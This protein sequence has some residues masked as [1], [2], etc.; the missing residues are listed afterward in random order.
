MSDAAHAGA[1]PRITAL[2]AAGR[3]PGLDAFAAGYGVE[4]K[5]L[6]E[7]AGRPMLA[8]VLAT[9]LAH[10]AI[11]A[12]RILTQTPDR[13]LAHP[14]IAALAADPRVSFRTGG[15]SV[16][17][18]V[19]GAIGDAPEDF[20]FLLTTADNPLLDAA[21][22]DHFIAAAHA[23]QADVAAAV[24]SE[25]VFRPRFPDGKRTWLRFRGGAYS[26]SNLFWFG[27]PAA[28]RALAVWQTIEQDRKRGR[29]VIRAFGVPILIGAGL[30]L[31]TL[32]GALARA[33]R[34][35]GLTAIAV[36]LPF[37]EACIDVD[38]PADHLL[39][40][41]LLAARAAR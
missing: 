1:P 21:M 12:V 22:I 36:E 35:L 26:G 39:A 14:A 28:Q 11:G 19:A 10:P 17:A 13:L 31:L 7:I 20:P 32:K 15:D 33:G 38:K 16:S 3:R 29:A 18:A 9:L 25:A 41:R 40:T 5:A 6:I 30:R 24:V 34:R 37:A 4:D 23:A 27:S 2:I 8:H